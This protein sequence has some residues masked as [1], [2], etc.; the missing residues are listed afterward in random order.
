[1][2]TKFNVFVMATAMIVNV[3]SV[4][5]GNG[6]LKV[7]DAFYSSKT[8]TSL[9]QEDDVTGC[10]DANAD[11][12]DAAAT[13][14]G[15]DQYGNIACNYSSCDDIPDAEG[16]YYTANYSAFHADFNADNCVQYGG[17]A[18]VIP[19]TDV[20]GCTDENAVNYNTEATVQSVDQYGNSTCVYST[21][22][23]VPTG[24]CLYVDG[25]GEFNDTFNAAN[26]EEYGGTSCLAGCLDANADNYDAN[27]AV[28][29]LDQY[30]NIACDYS[31]CDDIPD[32]E[33]C[34]YANNYSAFSPEFTAGHCVEYGGTA[35]T[36]RVDGVQGCLDEN[37]DNYNADATVQGLDQYGNLACNYSSCDDI[38]DAEG[39]F[40]TENYGALR[41]DF[42]AAQCVEYGGTACTDVVSG[43]MDANATNYDAAATSQSEDQ[44]GNLLCLYAS[45]DDIPELG[46]IYPD[47][48]G[49]FNDEGFGPEQC[50]GYGGTPCTGADVYGCMDADATNYNADANINSGCTYPT[51]NLPI[52]FEGVV[53]ITGFDG[54]TGTVVADPS[55]AANNV[56]QIVRDGGAAWAGGKIELTDTLDFSGATTSISMDVY[57]TAPVGT[58]VKLKLEGAGATERDMVT[59]VSGEW[60]TIYW[61]FTGEPKNFNFLVFMFDFG[62]VGD[63]SAN[64]T[65]YFDNIKQTEAD[66]D[67]EISACIDANASNY[68]AA[69][70]SQSYDQYQNSTCVYASCDV[71]PDADNGCIYSNGYAALRDDF[72]AAQCVQYGGT[73][74]SPDGGGNTVNGGCKDGQ[75]TNFD[76]VA[77]EQGYDEYGNSVC[78]YASCDVIPEPGCI[79]ADGFGVFNADF[80][81]A[82]CTEYGGTPC[83]G[84]GSS[85]EGC[86]DVN[87]DNYNA[88]ATVQGLDQYGNIAC[89]YSSCDDIPDAEG[90][91]YANNYSAF[92]EGFTAANCVE[93]GG[94]ACTDGVAGCMDAAADNYSA[95][96]TVQA[97]DQY[98][99][100]LCVFASCDVAPG[101]GCIYAESFGAY[102]EEFGHEAC[103][104][105]G[106]TPCGE[107]VVVAPLADC[108]DANATNYN[109]DATEAGLDQ[110]GNSVCVYTTCDDIPDLEGCIYVDGYSAFNPEFT[111]GQCQGYGGTPCTE[112]GDVLG[113]TDASASNYDASATVQA[114]DQWDNL[115][116]TYA[117]CADIPDVDN[118]CIYATTYAALRDDFTAENCA[119]YGGSPCTGDSSDVTGCMDANASNYNAAATL[120]GQD[121]YGNSV[122]VYTSCDDIPEPGCIYGDGFG[123]FNAEFDATACSGYGGTPCEG[124]GSSDAGCMDANATNYDAS[125]TVQA[126]DEYGNIL[127]IF[128]SCDDIPELGCI[129]AE[130]FGAYHPEFNGSACTEYGGTP[131]DGEQIEG[132]TDENASN[133]NAAANVAGV[134][135]YENS[136][137]VY[138]DCSEVPAGGGCI[139][140]DGFGTWS[141]GFAAEQ[142]TQYGG[143]PCVEGCIDANATNYDAA[144]A[145]QATDQYGNLLCTFASC[146]VTPNLGCIYE[147]SFGAYADGFGPDNCTE[148]GGTACAE[149][150][151]GCIDE[152]A[153]NYDADASEQALDEHGNILCSFATCDDAPSDGCNYTD[154]GSFGTYDEDFGHELC[155]QYGGTPCGTSEVIIPGGCMDENADNYD[156][157]ATEQSVD[158]WGNQLCDYASCDEVPGTGCMY[159]ASFATYNDNFS[160]ANCTQYGGTPC[161][162]ASEGCMEQGA[163]NYDATATIQAVDQWGNLA[164]TFATC[165]DIPDANGCIY[166]TTYAALRVDFT[167]EECESYGGTAC[168][169]AVVVEGPTSQSID[170]PN[171]WSMFSSYMVHDNM[172]L[173]AA[174]APIVSNVIIA[175]NNDGKAYLVEW[176]FNG[177]GDMIVGQGYQIKTNAEVTL[178]LTGSYATPEDHSINLVAGWNMIGYLSVHNTDAMD[179]LADINATGNLIIAKDYNGKGYLPEWGFNG[180]GEMVPG[181]GYQLKIGADDVLS[182]ASAPSRSANKSVMLEEVKHFEKPSV[183]D[184]NMTVVIEDAAWDAIPA[185]GSEVAAYDH[186]GNLIGSAVYSS[187]VTV[188]SVWGDDATTST[189]DGLSSAEVAKFKVWNAEDV[190][191]FNV[192][193]WSKGSAAYTTNA[194]NVASSITTINAMAELNSSSTKELVKVVNILGQEVSSDDVSFVGTVFFNI[195]D[196]GSVEKIVK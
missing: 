41:P 106:G 3:C 15:L 131:C 162:D 120:A 7:E 62:N 40:Y 26:C 100:I 147:T 35:C 21:C 86:L 151:A 150:S 186:A 188:L 64:S 89:D 135:Q 130:S 149:S 160:A 148:Y 139:Y 17:T 34:Y 10:M 97:E 32:A 27:A 50:A 99:N 98:G 163:S 108:M 80:S 95:D 82:Q 39:C 173:E 71:I 74:C 47:S 184:N 31:S 174:L 133:Y 187:P 22:A 49:A 60:E 123:S 77:L 153:S 137:C 55:D 20:E 170:L 146:D 129:Y 84:S 94:T 161:T 152:N 45:C 12:Y 4:F 104:G 169:E 113:C 9:L 75:A 5:A 93:Y 185:E 172:D 37:A 68:N 180:I 2:I 8:T 14:Q 126:E 25:F 141:E 177:V 67:A 121:Q 158:E 119:G 52:D 196:D 105:Y 128:T 81:A 136:V 195:Y 46:C 1:M 16:C 125:A 164:C 101:D 19:V 181:Q 85:D 54:G 23:S 11:N 189:K 183:T 192:K 91:Y 76:A 114:K 166:A 122:C 6:N 28:Q 78:V 159:A 79:Y 118:G 132:C 51:V 63:G 73:A 155:T 38:P 179:V 18:C 143:T 178:N 134:D 145:I 69:A 156:A 107:N 29:G 176:N 144:A 57:T 138:T 168:E 112:S 154:L 88:D 44:Y 70:T 58:T 165:D 83:E 115:L 59:T 190:K 33:G 157:T 102:N 56:A 171:G 116:C 127:C 53:G 175:K 142:C 103:S 42:T 124:S 30:G 90:C 24:G 96:A 66:P 61:D 117:S 65:F 48:F 72:T 36:E 193:N 110:Y 92:H 43:C 111:P 109:A 191:D 182:Y 194:I 140:S 87:A 13:V 167:A